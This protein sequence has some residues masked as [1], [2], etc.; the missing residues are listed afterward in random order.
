MRYLLYTLS[1]CI[2]MASCSKDKDAPVPLPEGSVSFQLNG[3][4]DTLEVP[5]SILKDSI[6]VFGI[7]ATLS[8]GAA[9]ATHWVN[10]ATDTTAI[11][12]YQAQYGSALLLPSTC[13]FFYKTMTQIAAGATQSDSAELNIN[14]QTQLKPYTTYVLPITIQSVDGNMEG[15]GT[16]KVCYYVFKTGPSGSISKTGWSITSYSSASGSNLPTKLID[17]N[18]LTT[19]WTTNITQSMPQWVIINFGSALT[20]SA[21]NYYLPPALKYPTL[22]GYPTSIEIETSMDGTTW[23]VK[24]IYAGNIT[25]NMQTLNTGITTAKYLRFTVLSSVIY[26]STYNIVSISGIK[27]LP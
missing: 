1:I 6:I 18:E 20:F 22:G 26:S 27:L 5:V 24:G 11:R 3:E 4:S 19:F 13:Y 10:F 7:K 14:T 17:D 21:V 25:D 8:T 16:D 2:V 12:D 15:A 23:A 9:T